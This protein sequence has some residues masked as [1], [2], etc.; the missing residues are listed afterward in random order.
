[1][2]TVTITSV[3]SSRCNMNAVAYQT[4]PQ[5]TE[6]VLKE[7]NS[8][9]DK[10]SKLSLRLEGA[11]VIIS[12][13]VIPPS[14]TLRKNTEEFLSSAYEAVERE[15]QCEEASHKLVVEQYA[16]AAVFQW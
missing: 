7:A 5:I 8:H 15:K 2:P 9:I 11:T 6:D 12:G 14:E 4:D 10:G 16:K 1:M 13:Q 3:V